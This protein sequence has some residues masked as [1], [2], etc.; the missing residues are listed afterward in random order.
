MYKEIKLVFSEGEMMWFLAKRGYTN[1]LVKGW[2]SNDAH[3]GEPG[4]RDEEVYIS[5][6]KKDGE[7][8]NLI[9][10]GDISQLS[11]NHR[12]DLLF[13]KELHKSLLKI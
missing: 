6:N 8:I 12:M 1:E 11:M 13:S 7:L 5:W 10:S 9:E 2:V 4:I 3:H